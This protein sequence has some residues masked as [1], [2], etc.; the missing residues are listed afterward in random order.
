MTMKGKC[1]NC[2]KIIPGAKPCWLVGVCD[3]IETEPDLHQ[4]NEVKE[5]YEEF[6]EYFVDDQICNERNEVVSL[7]KEISGSRDVF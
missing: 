6:E 4:E 3:S 1:P 5:E 7:Q 2:Q